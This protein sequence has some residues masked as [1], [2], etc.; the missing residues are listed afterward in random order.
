MYRRRVCQSTAAVSLG[1]LSSSSSSSSS[2]DPAQ[3]RR[4]LLEA[5]GTSRS[6]EMARAVWGTSIAS[7]TVSFSPSFPSSAHAVRLHRG[8]TRRRESPAQ[9]DVALSLAFGEYLHTMFGDG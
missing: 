7:H 1:P 5:C 4:G 6:D 2:F 3:P 9:T 8:R